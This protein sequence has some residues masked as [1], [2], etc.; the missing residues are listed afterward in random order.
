M[1]RR[2]YKTSKTMGILSLPCRVQ[3]NKMVCSET[4]RRTVKRAT[5]PDLLKT[6]IVKVLKI[7]RKLA[8]ARILLMIIFVIIATCAHRF[9][10]IY[11]NFRYSVCV[12]IASSYETTI[13]LHRRVV[14][15]YTITDRCLPPLKLKKHT[16]RI[17]KKY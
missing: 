10:N 5:D 3:S 7:Y 15:A 17:S 2:S 12:P 16:S 9:P 4:R 6:D 8:I 11:F 13:K 14:F 1:T